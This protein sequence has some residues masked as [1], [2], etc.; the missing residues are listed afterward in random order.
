M[1]NTRKGYDN[2]VL[3][4]LPNVLVGFVL[5]V[6]KDHHCHYS[7]SKSGILEFTLSNKRSLS[8]TSIVK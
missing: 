4:V 3:K 2:F 8:D 6:F 1:R 5:F 7:K